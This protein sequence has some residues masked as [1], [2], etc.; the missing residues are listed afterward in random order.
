METRKIRLCGLYPRLRIRLSPVPT[1][2][3]SLGVSLLCFLLLE[4]IFKTGPCH[5]YQF[6][7]AALTNYHQ[8]SS[9]KQHLLSYGFGGQK[10]EMSLTGTNQE[11][12][13]AAFLLEGLGDMHPCLTQPLETTGILPPTVLSSIFKVRDQITPTSTSTVTSSVTNSPTCFTYKGP[14]DYTRPTQIIRDNLSIS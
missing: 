4:I 10:L 2:S 9:L 3:H 8:F 12:T 6:P 14:C 13:R 5:C 11:V 1:D 7:I